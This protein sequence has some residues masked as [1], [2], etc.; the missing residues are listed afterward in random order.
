MHRILLFA[1]LACIPTLVP[2]AA[3][4]ADE[5]AIRADEG[6][7]LIDWK[8]AGKF[9]GKEVV[10]QGRI[11]AT[12]RAKTLIFLNFDRGRSFTAIIRKKNESDFPKPPDAMYM[13][14]LVQIRGRISVFRDKPQIEVSSPDQVKIV[15]APGETRAAD[16][17]AVRHDF[18]GTATIA[19][20]NV[21][22]LFDAHDDPYHD[23][24]G[25]PQ[26]PR[27]E[28]QKLAETIRK[29]NA[30]VLA[31]EEVENRGILEDFNRAM[32]GDLGYEHV[33]C[34]E[35]NDGRGI[36][37][38]V[39]S[40]FPVGPVT[41]YRHL[42][43]DDTRGGKTRFRR[44]L[45][46]VRI[47]PPNATAFDVYVVHL[48]S[49]R[50]GDTTEHVRMAET[51]AIRRILD[52]ELARDADARFVLCGDFNDTW[53]SNPIKQL[54]GSGA[55]ELKAF[56][57]EIPK[58]TPTYNK[59]PYRTMIDFIF[60]SPAMA[61]QYVAKS[62]HVVEGSVATSGSDHNPVVMKFNVRP[63]ARV[64][65]SEAGVSGGAGN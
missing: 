51:G 5:P 62:I 34:I 39:L 56:V 50:G 44:D 11:E 48:K 38:A 35:S 6:L 4:R 64:D 18:D 21:L 41:S 29:V 59:A 14:K 49:K 32:L 15:D 17:P 10:V 43:F 57:T 26:K 52:E 31:L 46:R 36:D 2:P 7:P 12:G 8:D 54:R 58:D 33:V 3:I 24:E 25:T 28:L 60:C 16:Q 53:D 45:L 30:D 22:N 37:C 1:L 47:E 20:Y 9:V 42:R 19:T 13:G 61:R 40:R 55:G 65:A 27:E 23:D 63:T